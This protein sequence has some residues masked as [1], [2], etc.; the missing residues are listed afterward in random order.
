M[1]VPSN[2][3]QTGTVSTD[4]DSIKE[5]LGTE[6]VTNVNV[7][8]LDIS[9]T[10]TG[11]AIASVNFETKTAEM[12]KAGCLW[13][14]DSW[15]H[16]EKYLYAFDA[17]QNYFW[18]VEKVDFIVVEAYSVNPSKMSGVNVVSEMQGSIKTAAQ[19]NGVKVT[20]MLPQS[21]R[22]I[23]R[24]KPNVAPGKNGKNVRDYKLPTKECVLTYMSVPDKVTSN[25]TGNLRTTPSDVYDSLAIALAWLKKFGIQHIHAKKVVFD[26]HIGVVNR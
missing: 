20:S 2:S 3:K 7:L 8:F 21:W 16:Q 5:E 12:T 9:S 6:K 17:I 13:F 18:V 19:S 24:I 1:I 22:S 26:G 25:I 23:L 10:C 14:D 11:Y 4:L 15:S